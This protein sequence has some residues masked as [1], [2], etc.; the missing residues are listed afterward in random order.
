[1][2]KMRVDAEVRRE[3]FEGIYFCLGNMQILNDQA[4][5]RVRQAM[6][7]EKQLNDLLA[8]VQ[9]HLDQVGEMMQRLQQ[10]FGTDW[11]RRNET[12]W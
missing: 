7:R 5:L 8:P 3:E 4:M 11:Q 9:Q 2:S 12:G 1:M 6:R 10:Q